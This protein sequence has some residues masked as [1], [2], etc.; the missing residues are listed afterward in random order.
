MFGVRAAWSGVFPPSSSKF[1]SDIPSPSSTM[2]FM[3]LSFRNK[4]SKFHVVGAPLAGAQKDTRKGYP[5]MFFHFLTAKASPSR[6]ELLMEPLQ[7]LPG[8][9]G[10]DLRGCEVRMTKHDL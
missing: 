1:L 10:V 4:C 3:S 6:V 5:Y 8:D 9:M 2:Y 7:P